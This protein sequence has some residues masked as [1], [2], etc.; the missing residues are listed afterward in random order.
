[1]SRGA[2]QNGPVNRSD[3][4]PGDVVFPT[5]ETGS[6]WI[7]LAREKGR[8]LH[9]GGDGKPTWWNDDKDHTFHSDVL[10]VRGNKAVNGRFK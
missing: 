3:L 7:V 8:M 2:W 4:L 6:P 1:M 9:V 10:I 5:D